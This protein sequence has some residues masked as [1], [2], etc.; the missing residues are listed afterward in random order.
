MKKWIVAVVASLFL[1]GGV[2]QT[3]QA[4]HS[5]QDI[6][7]Q[8]RFTKDVNYLVKYDII[9]DGRFFRPMAPAT[10]AEVADMLV[11][12]TEYKKPQQATK[13]KDVPASH[14]YSGAIQYATEQGIISGFPDG[15]FRP[16]EPVTRGQMA[17]LFYKRFPFLKDEL[18]LRYEKRVRFSDMTK[19]MKAYEAVQQMARYKVTSGYPNGTYRPNA[20]I[21]RGQL[22]AFIRRADTLEV[23]YDVLRDLI[24][25]GNF[26]QSFG[27][28]YYVMGE[29]QVIEG[30]NYNDNGDLTYWLEYIDDYSGRYKMIGHYAYDAERDLFYDD[31]IFINTGKKRYFNF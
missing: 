2:G 17:I 21:E 26:K 30:K 6:P 5:F 28:N 10:R 8:Y 12:T 22:A 24:R 29:W 25:R 31:L 16:N 14:P 27:Y 13:F 1:I 23:R 19:S 15:T 7:N 3:V 9:D 11:R 4:A 18:L 20:A